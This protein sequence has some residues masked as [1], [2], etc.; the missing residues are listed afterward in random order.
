MDN[1]THRRSFWPLGYPF[2]VRSSLSADDAKAAL[3]KQKMGW[4]EIKTGPRGWILGPFLCLELS[5]MGQRGPVVLARFAD[6]GFGSRLHGR[7]GPDLGS[8]SLMGL[9]TAIIAFSIYGFISQ[10]KILAPMSVL[11]SFALFVAV[12]LL[13]LRRVSPENADPLVRFVRRA[14]ETPTAHSTQAV[15]SRFDRTPVRSAKLN[16][17]GHEKGAPPSEHDVAQ[18]IF[19]MEPG[20]F[21]IIDLGSKTFMQTALEYDRFILEK[22]EGSDRTF[23]RARGDFESDDTI[24]AM[25]AY[26]RASAPSKQI[27]WERVRP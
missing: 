19:A 13:W 22:C 10:I 2:E 15:P 8:L 3:R 4:F 6:D 23:Y 5:A 21:L 17:D 25:T 9:I 26:L 18:A 27:I 11:G 12:G 24:D 14:L 16:I 1:V 20:G 7:A